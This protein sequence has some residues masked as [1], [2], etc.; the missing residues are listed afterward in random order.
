MYCTVIVLESM[1]STYLLLGVY[2]TPQSIGCQGDKVHTIVCKAHTISQ[3]LLASGDGLLPVGQRWPGCRGPAGGCQW[4]GCTEPQTQGD[5]L[6]L[7]IKY[8]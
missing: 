5:S 6:V 4:R 3:M 2:V 8:F 7:I 1:I